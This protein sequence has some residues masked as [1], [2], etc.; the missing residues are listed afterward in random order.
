MRL[1]QYMGKKNV[2]GKKLREIRKK[3]GYSQEALA[4]KMQVMAINIDQQ[5]VSKIEHNRRL[6]LDYDLK[7]FCEALDIGID[8]LLGD[9]YRQLKEKYED[10]LYR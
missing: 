4:A 9:V 3:K 5:A 1:A 7:G 8:E 2:I 6:V 10:T